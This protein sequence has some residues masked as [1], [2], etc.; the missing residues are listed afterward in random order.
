MYFVYAIHNSNHN[1]LYIG[2]THDLD[3]RIKMHN[4]KILEKSYT[5]RFEGEWKL[6]Y[7][8]KAETRQA[9]LKRERQL[10]SYRG[11]QFLKQYIPR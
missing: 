7:S 6:I 10:K 2:Q 1:K 11:R 3:L 5:S 8:E 9:A 4:E